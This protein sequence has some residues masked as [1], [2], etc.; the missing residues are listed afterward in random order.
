MQIKIDKNKKRSGKLHKCKEKQ[1]KSEYK[2]AAE[3]KTQGMK[4]VK[5]LS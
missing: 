5:S 1:T 2:N 3:Q 4:H